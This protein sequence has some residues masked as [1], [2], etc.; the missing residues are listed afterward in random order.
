MPT[1]DFSYKNAKSSTCAGRIANSKQECISVVMKYID[2]SHALDGLT[3]NDE[4]AQ[5]SVRKA[6]TLLDVG[7][8]TPEARHDADMV[9]KFCTVFFPRPD[10]G[11][12]AKPVRSGSR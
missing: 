9:L 3:G 1:G 6:S 5:I 8:Q 2:N 11:S 10:T 12:P 4:A 7:C